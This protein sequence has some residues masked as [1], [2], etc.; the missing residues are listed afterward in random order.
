MSAQYA[1]CGDPIRAWSRL[2]SDFPL[3]L[4]AAIFYQPLS[5]CSRQRVTIHVA[6]QCGLLDPISQNVKEG[7]EQGEGVTKA[8]SQPKIRCRK[9]VLATAGLPM[10]DAPHTCRFAHHSSIR[11]TQLM[12]LRQNPRTRG[13]LSR[14]LNVILCGVRPGVVVISVARKMALLRVARMTVSR[15]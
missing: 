15:A 13:S 8:R 11:P 12:R 1:R 7:A 2:T 5:D 14:R 6:Q 9:A 4:V 10:V 3:W